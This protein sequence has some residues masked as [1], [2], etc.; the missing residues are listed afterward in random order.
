MDWAGLG[1]RA[2][3][4]PLAACGTSACSMA[5]ARSPATE[6]PILQ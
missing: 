3:G 2:D 5:S 1:D 4:L 6:E